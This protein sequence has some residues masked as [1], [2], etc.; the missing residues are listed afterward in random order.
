V[1]ANP[2]RGDSRSRCRR[3]RLSGVRAGAG[4]LW[5]SASMAMGGHREGGEGCPSRLLRRT[6][7]LLPMHWG[8]GYG[9]SVSLSLSLC[10][11]VSVSLLVPDEMVRVE[12]VKKGWCW[13]T[14]ESPAESGRGRGTGEWTRGERR[15]RE[16]QYSTVCTVQETRDKRQGNHDE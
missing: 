13:F 3:R 4:R 7:R 8:G 11:C 12:W 2:R 9:V 15:G 14:G 6:P 1:L 16:V 5:C 10:L